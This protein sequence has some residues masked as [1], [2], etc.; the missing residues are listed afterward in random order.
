MLVSQ[1]ETAV[2]KIPAAL[3]ELPRGLMRFARILGSP[4]LPSNG[5]LMSLLFWVLVALRVA[6]ESDIDACPL[7]LFRG[8][9]C[10]GLAA[11]VGGDAAAYM[12]M[13]CVDIRMEVLREDWGQ[14]GPPVA[15]PALGRAALC[16]QL[17]Q[18]KRGGFVKDVED[19]A[20]AR[21]SKLALAG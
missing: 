10:S 8:V 21:A 5:Y 19:L 6:S 3:A 20:I 11:V 14:H 13:A 1:L 18:F 7:V 17:C 2:S 9:T 12:T 4:G 15:W 16:N